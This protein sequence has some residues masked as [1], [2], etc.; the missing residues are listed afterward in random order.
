MHSHDILLLTLRSVVRD[1][2][3]RGRDIEGCIKQWFSFVKP[4]FHRYVEWQRQVADIIV[5][6]GIDNHVAIGLVV[7]HVRKTLSHKSKEHQLHL[8]KLGKKAEDEPLSRNVLELE[9]GT[10]LRGV[11]TIILDPLT[12]REDFIFYFDRVATMLLEK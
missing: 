3:E 1:V 7:D 12:S 4:N 5:P 10:Q 6:R 8:R 9:K 2:R 11:N